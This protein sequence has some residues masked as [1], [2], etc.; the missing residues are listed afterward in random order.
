MKGKLPADTMQQSLESSEN[1]QRFLKMQE[2]SFSKMQQEIS[3]L[4][5]KIKGLETKLSPYAQPNMI[6]KNFDQSEYSSMPLKNDKYTN[7]I[8]VVGTHDK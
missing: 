7:N 8:V 2:E 1:N 4:Q 6:R 3:S 5:K